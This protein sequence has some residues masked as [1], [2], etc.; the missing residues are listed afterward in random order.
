[1]KLTTFEQNLKFKLKT[2]LDKKMLDEDFY[3]DFSFVFVRLIM[4]LI[5]IT[6]CAKNL[7]KSSLIKAKIEINDSQFNSFIVEKK[8]K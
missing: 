6:Y 5:T 2:F 7:D 4:K 1:M 8:I 3:N